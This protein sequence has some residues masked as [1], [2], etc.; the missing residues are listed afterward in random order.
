MHKI[1]LLDIENLHKTEKELLNFLH[2]YQQVYVIYAKSPVNF[3][4]DG[5][6]Q[7]SSYVSAGQLKIIKMPQVGKNSADFG[8]AFI[9]GQLSQKL[10]PA[11]SRF[12]LMSNDHSMQYIADLLKMHGFQVQILSEKPLLPTPQVLTQVDAELDHLLLTYCDYLQRSVNR[13]AKAE[14]L[15]NSI[16]SLLRVQ[17]GQVVMIFEELKKQKIFKLEGVKVSYQ[18]AQLKQYLKKQVTSSKPSPSVKK[19]S[20]KTKVTSSEKCLTQTTTLQVATVETRTVQ[21]SKAVVFS[22]TVEQLC[23][24]LLVHLPDQV[25]RRPKY[26]ASFEVILSRFVP[27]QH[28]AQTLKLLMDNQLI[29]VSERQI[30]YSPRLLGN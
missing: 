6:Q 7:L 27:A 3:S 15:C 12:E 29:S 22:L 8:L 26:M 30:V 14:T 11:N 20:A 10:S 16:K 21:S 25:E 4:L 5:L 1:L 23:Q 18:D 24:Q 19:T 28:I 17:D 13:P 2:K 9:A